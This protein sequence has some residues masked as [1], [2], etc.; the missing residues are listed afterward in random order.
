MAI[1]MILLYILLALI[2]YV[3][4]SF[5]KRSSYWKSQGITNEEPH[6]LLGNMVGLGK[7]KSFGDVW[8]EYYEKFKGSGPFLGF[9]F[10]H[11][12]SAFLL[13][14]ALIKNVLIKDFNKF[15]DRG[16][17][18]N[19]KDDPL[20]GQLFLIDGNKW[21]RM[22]NKLSPTFTSGKMRFMF[23][24]VTQICE[25]FVEVLA[26]AAE[27][28]P[29]VEMRE[30]LARFTTD[31]IG[32][33]AFGIECNSLKNPNAIFRVYGRK[34][35]EEQRH[36]RLVMAFMNSFPELSKALKMK[37]F[38]ED[39]IQFFLRIVRETVEYREKNNVRRNDFMDMLIDLKNKKL[40]KSEHG[41]DLTN[42][43]MEEI[44][45]QAHV[46]FNAG[47]ETSSTTMGFAL[48]ELAQNQEMQDRV[49]QE[50]RDMYEK[51]ENKF[52]YESMKDMPYL[53][54]II[55]ETLRM[56][57][58][59]P[60]LNRQALEDY[61]V[62]GNPKYVIK[63]G[64]PVL[65]PVV[66]IHHDERYYPE[67]HK[68]NPDNF[69]PELV[70]Q[71]DSILYMPFGEGPRNCIGMRFG[72]MQTTVGLAMLLKNFKFSV[73]SE[74]QIPLQYDKK[75]FLISSERGITLRVTRI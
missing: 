9:Y 6:P 20:S 52:S 64:M 35:L 28:N 47:F 40:I 44:T 54:Q 59:V 13:D 17:F 36:G 49:R 23:P 68:F 37:L 19:P 12:P 3:V 61:V 8:Q 57:T 14:P 66:G 72:K 7:S 33:C 16:F 27:E 50:I 4:I 2:A 38:P 63:K 24:I 69:A 32:S 22:R 41:D 75:S 58:V 55:A 56:Y 46:F 71:R 18:H 43:T 31:V 74:T 48:Y 34:G 1:F 30:M 29:V 65:I 26:K 70:A 21:R 51:W 60:V 53:E 42:L 25:E 45:A 10:F 67:P 73:C 62:P 5:R 15:T 39:V 11:R